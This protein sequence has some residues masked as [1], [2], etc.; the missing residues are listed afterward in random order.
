MS[1]TPSTMIELGT[2]APDFSLSDVCTG[3]TIRLR[4]FEGRQGLLIIFM[5]AHCPYVKLVE[6]ELAQMG[7]DYK[8]KSL[9]IVG[10]C[11]NDAEKYPDD[12]PEK[13]GEQAENLHLTFPYCYDESQS[14]ATA[15]HAACTPDFFL[16]DKHQLL[17]YRGQLDDSRPGNNRPVTGLDLRTAIDALLADKAITAEQIP[18]IGCNIKWKPGNEPSY[19]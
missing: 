4:D 3:E 2:R 17:V 6:T 15:Y 19:F 11:S 16:F 18:A 8:N 7:A 13:L 1:L 5:C 10:I 14:I 12:A 9:G